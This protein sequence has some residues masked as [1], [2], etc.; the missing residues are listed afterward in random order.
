MK[1]P[2]SAR[3]L[4]GGGNTS[5]RSIPEEGVNK[6]APITPRHPPI[7]D[8]RFLKPEEKKARLD[9]ETEMNCHNKP[10][11]EIVEIETPTTRIGKMEK[12]NT[13]V[14]QKVNAN[15]NAERRG[16]ETENNI[17]DPSAQKP[18]YES[19]VKTRIKAL[20]AGQ[21]ININTNDGM[22]Y[23]QKAPQVRKLENPSQFN[24]A[25]IGPNDSNT[26][27]ISSA[28]MPQVQMTSQ[29]HIALHSVRSSSDT[30]WDDRLTDIVANNRDMLSNDDTMERFTDFDLGSCS[31]YDDIFGPKTSPASAIRTPSHI[32]AIT[33]PSTRI[34]LM[35]TDEFD[36]VFQSDNPLERTLVDSDATLN[37]SPQMERRNPEQPLP[38]T[39][40][41]QHDPPKDAPQPQQYKSILKTKLSDNVSCSSVGPSAPKTKNRTSQRERDLRRSNSRTRTRTTV[42][43][44]TSSDSSNYDD[45]FIPFTADK[46]ELVMDGAR[47]RSS[48]VERS[49]EN[50][51]Q[52][53]Q[54]QQAQQPE[55][56]GKFYRNGSK[57]EST[58][59]NDSLFSGDDVS[60]RNSF[61]VMTS[62]DN[63]SVNSEDLREEG[64]YD[65]HSA[66]S[67]MTGTQNENQLIGTTEFTVDRVSQNVGPSESVRIEIN[68]PTTSPKMQTMLKVPDIEQGGDSDC[69]LEPITAS[70]FFGV[71]SDIP[72]NAK[73]KK[74]NA[75]RSGQKISQ[76][77]S[78][79]SKMPVTVISPQV[80]EE[81]QQTTET[82]RKIM[83]IKTCKDISFEEDKPADESTCRHKETGLRMNE[84]H[85]QV[86]DED[87]KILSDASGSSVSPKTSTRS[88][89][90]RR[91]SGKINEQLDEL[92]I[93][94]NSKLRPKEND[95]PKQINRGIESC[96]SKTPMFLAPFDSSVDAMQRSQSQPILT[97]SEQMEYYDP[98]QSVREYIHDDFESKPNIEN[99]IHFEISYQDEHK[100][101]YSDEDSSDAEEDQD[102]INSKKSQSSTKSSRGDS[103][104]AQCSSG[105]SES[106][107][108][109]S[110]LS[111]WSDRCVLDESFENRGANSVCEEDTF[112]QA[113]QDQM[114][115]TR[116]LES[117]KLVDKR[118]A[119]AF[120]VMST[121]SYDCDLEGSLTGS[122]NYTRTCSTDYPMDKSE[123]LER[124]AHTE[125]WLQEDVGFPRKV[126]GPSSNVSTMSNRDSASAVSIESLS[127]VDEADEVYEGDLSPD[128]SYGE[129]YQ[130]GMMSPGGSR[131]IQETHDTPL[132]GVRF[133]GSEDLYGFP[134]AHPNPD[135]DLD[136]KL[137]LHFLHDSSQEEEE[138]YT[139]YHGHQPP[140]DGDDNIERQCVNGLN[141][142]NDYYYSSDEIEGD[143]DGE[144]DMRYQGEDVE[145]GELLMV[146][147]MEHMEYVEGHACHVE[148][149][150]LSS[151]DAMGQ[152]ILDYLSDEMEEEGEVEEWGDEIEDD[153]ELQSGVVELEG[154]E[155][156]ETV[157]YTDKPGVIIHALHKKRECDVYYTSQEIPGHKV[158]INYNAEKM[159]KSGRSH[160]QG[161]GAKEEYEKDAGPSII[162]DSARVR[163][164]FKEHH[165]H[166]DDKDI[167]H[168]GSNP[169][170][171]ELPDTDEFFLSFEYDEDH[172]RSVSDH[173]VEEMPD[174]HN[175]D[176]VDV[177]EIEQ[178]E[179]IDKYASA[180]LGGNIMHHNLSTVIG[181][182]DSSLFQDGFGLIESNTASKDDQNEL[183]EN[184]NV[185]NEYACTIPKVI[186]KQLV[187]ELKLFDQRRLRKTSSESSPDES[188][189]DNHKLSPKVLSTDGH[190][191]E[192]CHL[193]VANS[194]Q[195]SQLSSNIRDPILQK[196]RS[197]TEEPSKQLNLQ[198]GL[199]N[200]F[201]ATQ[202]TEYHL[203]DSLVLN[204]KLGA[205]EVPD[206]HH[207]QP[208]TIEEYIK[209]NR[210][211]SSSTDEAIPIKRSG[212]MSKER[213][214]SIRSFWQQLDEDKKKK[215]G[216]EED[217]IRQREDNRNKER[218]FKGRKE[219]ADKEMGSQDSVFL[220]S[221]SSHVETRRDSR[222][223]SNESE[224]TE[225]AANSAFAMK[226]PRDDKCRKREPP[227]V[228]P[229]PPKRLIRSSVDNLAATSYVQT[230]TKVN[231][232]ERLGDAQDLA[233]AHFDNSTT[234]TASNNNKV[235]HVD[236]P[237]EVF[238]NQISTTTIT[239]IS[240]NNKTNKVHSV[241]RQ[242]KVREIA[243]FHELQNKAV[244]DMATRAQNKA[245][246]KHP[247]KLNYLNQP[248]EQHRPHESISR[249]EVTPL[250]VEA[251][252]VEGKAAKPIAL[253]SF[254]SKNRRSEKTHINTQS[255]EE[256]LQKQIIEKGLSSV[257]RETSSSGKLE[258]SDTHAEQI[259]IGADNN[260]VSIKN[261]SNSS[262]TLANTKLIEQPKDLRK[263]S[264]D[265]SE[266]SQLK[267]NA[268]NET[269]SNNILTFEKTMEIE[270]ASE[271]FIWSP[272][273]KSER[274]S[275][276]VN[277][278]TSH[279][280]LKT[281]SSIGSFEIQSDIIENSHDGIP[282][283]VENIETK[284]GTLFTNN[285]VLH[286]PTLDEIGPLNGTED[287]DGSGTSRGNKSY[288]ISNTSVTFEE[289][290]ESDS[291]LK[292]KPI[293]P[294]PKFNARALAKNSDF[295]LPAFAK[296][297]ATYKP[298]TP[299]QHMPDKITAETSTITEIVPNLNLKTALQ[300]SDS[301][302]L[303]GLDQLNDGGT[304]SRELKLWVADYLKDRIS[305]KHMRQGFESESSRIPA[306]NLSS[307]NSSFYGHMPLSGKHNDRYG[308]MSDG[309][310]EPTLSSRSSKDT[311]VSVADRIAKMKEKMEAKN[312]PA[313]TPERSHPTKSQKQFASLLQNRLIDVIAQESDEDKS[314]KE[315]EKKK[316][317]SNRPAPDS[318]AAERQRLFGKGGIKSKV[319]SF[320]PDLTSTP[321][322]S[323]T[324]T[325]PLLGV[326]RENIASA[327]VSV[328]SKVSN[329]KESSIKD[330]TDRFENLS[331]SF[332]KE[333]VLRT[334]RV[335]KSDNRKYR[336]VTTSGV[337]FSDIQQRFTIS[338]SSGGSS[339]TESFSIAKDKTRPNSPWTSA[340]GPSPLVYDFINKL[341]S[342]ESTDGEA[343]SASDQHNN[344][345]AEFG[346]AKRGRVLERVNAFSSGESSLS[347][348][349]SSSLNRQSR[350]I[351]SGAFDRNLVS[352]L[353][354]RVESSDES[355]ATSLSSSLSLQTGELALRAKLESNNT[356]AKVRQKFSLES[357]VSC[358]SSRSSSID[359]GGD[360]FV[361]SDYSQLA[362]RQP[363]IVENSFENSRDIEQEKTTISA[364]VLSE[365]LEAIS[366][367]CPNDDSAL[368]RNKRFAKDR[369]H[370]T[371]INFQELRDR[372]NERRQTRDHSPPQ[373]PAFKII[374]ASSTGQM[375]HSVIPD[376]PA[377]RQFQVAQSTKFQRRQS[378][379][380]HQKS[381]QEIDKQV[382]NNIVE[383]PSH[384]EKTF[385]PDQ[386]QQQN[387]HEL[388]Q[389]HHH[390]QQQSQHHQYRHDH[391]QQ[392]QTHQS[393]RNSNT[394][395]EQRDFPIGQSRKQSLPMSSSNSNAG[396]T[397]SHPRP[398]SQLQLTTVS[399]MEDE[400]GDTFSPLISARVP[401]ALN[402][403][404]DAHPPPAFPFSATNY[405]D[406]MSHGELA[407]S[408]SSDVDFHKCHDEE[409]VD[410]SNPTPSRKQHRT[411]KSQP[412]NHQPQEEVNISHH[413]H[414]YQP[415]HQHHPCHSQLES[416]QSHQPNIHQIQHQHLQHQHQ[417][418]HQQ[419]KQQQ[420]T[421]PHHH[422]HHGHQSP[423]QSLNS[424]HSS[425]SSMSSSFTSST[426]FSQK[427][428]QFS[429]ELISSG[430]PITLIDTKTEKGYVRCRILSE[431]P[432]E[433]EENSIATSDNSNSQGSSTISVASV[434]HNKRCNVSPSQ[435]HQK[436]NHLSP[437]PPPSIVI[438]EA[439]A[440][441]IAFPEEAFSLSLPT[442]SS[443]SQ[444]S[445]L[446]GGST[447]VPSR[448]MSLGNE[449]LSSS[450][451]GSLHLLSPR[452][453]SIC[454]TTT[455]HSEH[456]LMAGRGDIR[457][458]SS[459]QDLGDS[460]GTLLLSA[461]DTQ[462]STASLSQDSCVA[463][464]TGSSAMSGGQNKDKI[465]PSSSMSSSR[466]EHKRRKSKS[467]FMQGVMEKRRNASEPTD[468]QSHIGIDRD[469]GYGRR[470]ISSTSDVPPSTHGVTAVFGPKVERKKSNGE[471]NTLRGYSKRFD[472]LWARFD[473]DQASDSMSVSAVSECLCVILFYII[474]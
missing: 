201:Q 217:W 97:S 435:I 220:D 357:P 169:R 252:S 37:A 324:P 261:K 22:E 457:H 330:V 269:K 221:G 377:P 333:D 27:L 6:S 69:N 85:I 148:M 443:N 242:S 234:A 270:K 464:A 239:T 112:A 332:S 368:R 42:R 390:H 100:S 192:D 63:L 136:L 432:I 182:E 399:R 116:Q 87:G 3:Q 157:G 451:A 305:D 367:R 414:Q 415:Q 389:P 72:F 325:N 437:P 135:N 260:K 132:D 125:E 335:R 360:S 473:P 419:Q 70:G 163:E 424:S 347:N 248:H 52:S 449:S 420:P 299:L 216:R 404:S 5:A 109:A 307:A 197:E 384:S 71:K 83:V 386:H 263:P 406:D 398:H 38:P 315:R 11:Q 375:E 306:D 277:K 340:A 300:K 224:K 141:P 147:H 465:S 268:A 180:V 403:P 105:G 84:F 103:N 383:K 463:A 108:L 195:S 151:M 19:D 380:S 417:H 115:H 359:R 181:D 123:I 349:R 470:P 202:S 459:A 337:P 293:I 190:V 254:E 179:D 89:E 442:I 106:P 455:D 303:P 331:E 253:P 54:L 401:E 296:K 426:T 308:S 80:E 462:S 129:T 452:R 351:V 154:K 358:S 354:R 174:T 279:I 191:I 247:L 327:S 322:L 24:V 356:V 309:L 104:I 93:K 317:K 230:D 382:N 278:Q 342:A 225:K 264:L 280:A 122:V 81:Y 396:V 56:V 453:A 2:R 471:D 273:N 178:F 26:I 385:P 29:Q 374:Y 231:S 33:T 259:L 229:K 120:S 423:V 215:K 388:H 170:G 275:V 94:L 15:R 119:S 395:G 188:N 58:S 118:K 313:S 30:D 343:R 350:E 223:F 219:K 205:A 344:R 422:H 128:Q 44:D 439:P 143:E 196:P 121:V 461:T 90:L 364:G 271:Q 282:L 428:R 124:R 64:Y 393:R 290:V 436:H 281:Q 241:E 362:R 434:I 172:R 441:K 99:D 238:G 312:E 469:A 131:P 168:K 208:R 175:G 68:S 366:N 433:T 41:T 236:K 370:T 284:D 158:D 291:S 130:Y 140:V 77:T 114:E 257:R 412:M 18:F 43:V 40:Q 405:E 155:P 418:H 67:S 31:S 378:S 444:K 250:N 199:Q 98:S 95:E 47:R 91:N 102:Q 166:I 4:T 446:I 298:S 32:E 75:R 274:S 468:A 213:R 392:I 28:R 194:N 165:G 265:N 429:Q 21:C 319:E 353:V 372:Y 249:K 460:Q 39:T 310:S 467:K 391:H 369:R 160:P 292:E 50:A 379:P 245:T 400:D 35:S 127:E 53:Q 59:E 144:Y 176:I 36:P 371:Q 323:R 363:S 173:E 101:H 365:T 34:E 321:S 397:T 316:K 474:V 62:A 184:E 286:P 258:T 7:E 438:K 152:N 209:E 233:D 311:K 235:H 60:T 232:T 138:V 218:S 167:V 210:R 346:Q 78:I 177:L 338:D 244:Q 431:T 240:T 295:A 361:V 416:I 302:S 193:T 183:I 227:A 162:T 139:D 387:Y 57:I 320:N 251:K 472:A 48:V 314:E 153:E 301:P 134:D 156:F 13:V 82:P 466:Y 318:W 164:M 61:S 448:K 204:K 206:K 339:S 334:N 348:S 272:R 111:N 12:E 285:A 186:R 185:D 203:A 336:R 145:E 49:V 228:A 297:I 110:P 171:H 326:Q 159:K 256:V 25:H 255:I 88:N 17:V 16:V 409:F 454:S 276:V 86:S 283:D 262:V 20:E 74:I 456:S 207:E 394:S 352:E 427:T 189:D 79:W 458:I 294:G 96:R 133:E 45:H 222:A 304:S 246:E 142:N 266:Y 187:A 447:F 410:T 402:L 46:D 341:T 450:R 445:A 407:E 288:E 23:S 381:S 212:S 243:Q 198:N 287:T 8:I 126:E 328:E 161:E 421:L 107:R 289:S 226:P 113:V 66:R 355:G 411:S 92:F 211:R 65:G 329:L 214:R 10:T 373:S 1:T 376:Y 413:S 137:P 149:D 117:S 425:Q 237:S 150:V 55:V 345:H 200:T 267:S 73:K 440:S 408:E 9:S 76:M 51:N 146:E 14:I 430:N